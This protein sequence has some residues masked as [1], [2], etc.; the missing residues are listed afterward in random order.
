MGSKKKRIRKLEAR[1]DELERKVSIL[2]GNARMASESRLAWA[3]SQCAC[4]P[5][6]PIIDMYG[7]VVYD[8]KES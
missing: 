7:N 1:V 3:M 8:P 5:E 4:V 2:C 6:V